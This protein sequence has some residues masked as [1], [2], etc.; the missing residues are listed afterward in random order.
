MQSLL[1]HGTKLVEKLALK[2]RVKHTKANVVYFK[3]I[4]AV[5]LGRGHGIICCALART[6]FNYSTKYSYPLISL[7]TADPTSSA[8]CASPC[9]S[10]IGKEIRCLSWLKGEGLMELQ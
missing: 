7:R 4:Q 2:W 8:E 5:R 3:T 10:G 9:A 6:L 1:K